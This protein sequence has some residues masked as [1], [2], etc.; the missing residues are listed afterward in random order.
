MAAA[1]AVL[2]RP[3][4]GFFLLL[5][6]AAPP[7]TRAAEGL[8][9]VG[10]TVFDGTGAPALADAVVVV[11]K[12]TI[13]SVGPRSRVALP[14][15]IPY[16]DGRGLFVVP[17]RVGR[18]S[19]AAALR[20]RVRSGAAFERAL[21]DVLGTEAAT[22]SDG[23]IKPGGPA[24]LVVLDKDPRTSMDPLGAV[25]RTYVKGREVVP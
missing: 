22:P 7:S 18:P 5:T 15:G 20:E 12:E 1:E 9:I 4:L 21:A 23:T 14:K 17:G 19:V 16:V 2:K 24:D 13:S 25:K 11:L 6:L 3:A 8:A 10:A